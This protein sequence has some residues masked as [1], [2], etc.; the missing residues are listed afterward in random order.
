MAHWQF[1]GDGNYNGRVE[2][3]IAYFFHVAYDLGLPT[4]DAPLPPQRTLDR[5]LRFDA[6]SFA[7]YWP[8]WYEIASR[9]E[10]DRLYPPPEPGEQITPVFVGP[11]LKPVYG[12]TPEPKPPSRMPDQFSLDDLELAQERA[13]RRVTGREANPLASPVDGGDDMPSW[14]K[15]IDQVSRVAAQGLSIF[16]LTKAQDKQERQAREV[17]GADQRPSPSPGFGAATIG[18]LSLTTIAIIALIVWLLRK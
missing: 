17:N 8:A 3:P 12:V 2:G 15:T 11:P 5:W 1:I 7:I 14:L 4:A 6:D 9:G 13:L 18:G 16:G 10:W